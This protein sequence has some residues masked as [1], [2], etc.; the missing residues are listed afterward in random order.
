MTEAE[1]H[2]A[3]TGESS[4]DQV[5]TDQI[6]TEL[7]G[8]TLTVTLNRP[9]VR[10]AQTPQMWRTLASIARGVPSHVRFVLL[11]GSGVDFSAGLDRAVLA[12]TGTDGMIAALQADATGFI[13]SAQEGFRAWQQIPQTVIAAVQGNVIGAGF[14]LA[15]ASDI[16]IAEP[17]A[18]FALRE[19]AIGLVPDLGGT[20]AL[21]DALGYR[22]TF[23][24]CAT[25]DFLSASDAADA[26]LVHALHDDLASGVADVCDRL[27]GI[28]AG[29]VS[30]VKRL[31]RQVASDRDSWKAEREIQVER[32][33]VLFGQARS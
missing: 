6:L 30:D 1:D 18:R 33:R 13:E 22:R 5:L 26:G 2:A 19:T 21:I 12:D 27:R 9:E 20:G 29:A 8:D 31:L 17:N 3:S 14:Q 25:G 4:T 10:N 28:D 24:L 16:L 7:S 32:L 15:L 11:T 23:A